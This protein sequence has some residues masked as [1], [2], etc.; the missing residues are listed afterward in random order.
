MAVTKEVMSIREVIGKAVEIRV[1]NVTK[2]IRVA[3]NAAYA[4]AYKECEVAGNSRPLSPEEEAEVKEDFTDQYIY[5]T[6]YRDGIVLSAHVMGECAKG[7]EDP[8]KG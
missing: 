2:Q 4:K 1:K 8:E 7:V 5:Y 3:A 6:G